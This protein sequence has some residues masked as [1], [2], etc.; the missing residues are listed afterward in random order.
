M[1]VTHA[2]MQAHARTYTH[3]RHIRTVA[4]EAQATADDATAVEVLLAG[5][6]QRLARERQKHLVL[7]FKLGRVDAAVLIVGDAIGC[8]CVGSAQVEMLVLGGQARRCD[9]CGAD[10]AM[11]QALPELFHS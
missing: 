11:Q 7:R 5:V 1:H 4:W 2:H 3:A 6:C 9:G 8:R 10:L